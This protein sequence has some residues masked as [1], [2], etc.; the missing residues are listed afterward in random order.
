[1]P[2]RRVSF[3]L[4]GLAVLAV[5]GLALA[6]AGTAPRALPPGSESAR[7]LAAGPF[8]VATR[9]AT[10][11]DRSRPT[12]ENGNYAG[13]QER[14]LRVTLWYPLG[15]ARPH[16]LAVSSHGVT[17]NRLGGAHLAQHLASHG[18]VVLAADRPLTSFAAPGGPAVDDVVSQPGA[19]S[20]LIERVLA[21]EGG[22][23]AGFSYITSGVLRLLGNPD[24][25]GCAALTQNLD[26]EPGRDPFEGLTDEEQGIVDAS[27]APLPCQHPYDEV[28]SA[29][30]QQ[31]L[32]TLAVRAF[33]GSHFAREPR[34]RR[35]HA[36]F[37][38]DV[39]PREVAEVR[40]SPARR[41]REARGRRPLAAS[42]SPG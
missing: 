34:E 36:R 20:F 9:E 16:P 39:L 40:Y 1:M 21:L 14:S 18:M 7:R 19:P 8:R 17:S 32:E 12:A 3:G 23:H 24:A 27:A 29:R 5:A 41:V 30:R 42:L 38:S 26:I 10:W 4:L 37:L 35:G 25:L 22:T 28:M 2:F 11:V 6:Y 31:M 15:D 33:F 13:S